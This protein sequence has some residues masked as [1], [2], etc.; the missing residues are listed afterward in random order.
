VFVIEESVLRYR[1]CDPEVL[2]GQLLH[3]RGA[4]R[5]PTVWLGSSR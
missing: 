4:A 1:F 3:L 5:L 2:R